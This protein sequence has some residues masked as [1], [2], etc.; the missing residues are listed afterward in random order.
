[1]PL[2]LVPQSEPTADDQMRAIAWSYVEAGDVAVL[3]R[4]ESG[5]RAVARLSIARVRWC[6]AVSRCPVLRA[7]VDEHP[8][9]PLSITEYGAAVR[10]GRISP[11]AHRV[12]L[13]CVAVS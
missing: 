5:V 6:A 3:L 11:R 12:L 2:H 13:E 4:D 7:A 8:Q 1:M 9:L 10:G